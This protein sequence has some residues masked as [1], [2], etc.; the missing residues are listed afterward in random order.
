ML[1]TFLRHLLRIKKNAK[2]NKTIRNVNEFLYN[3][4]KYLKLLS[5]NKNLRTQCII[6]WN[7]Q[8]F[9]EWFLRLEY[10]KSVM[11]HSLTRL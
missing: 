10:L 4:L 6:N 1:T 3:T 11:R 9:N 7:N 2:Y 8:F 5:F